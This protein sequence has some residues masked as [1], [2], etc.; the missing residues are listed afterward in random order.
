MALFWSAYN[1]HTVID[2]VL[3]KQELNQKQKAALKM[4]Y[5]PGSS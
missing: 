5:L 1:L 3:Q 4:S 2:G